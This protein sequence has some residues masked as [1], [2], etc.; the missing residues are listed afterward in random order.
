LVMAR[1]TPKS[2]SPIWDLVAPFDERYGVRH[3][4]RAEDAVSEKLLKPFSRD[5][6]DNHCEN[7]IA[8][9][10]VLPASA[11]NEL[12]CILLLQ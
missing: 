1:L 11:G 10:A 5:S 4:K 12:A 9:I 3:S 7:S 8:G 6:L 2:E